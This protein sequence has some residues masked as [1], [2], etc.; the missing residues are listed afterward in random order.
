MKKPIS[1][2]KHLGDNRYKILVPNPYI[3]ELRA[4][5]INPNDLSNK[6]YRLNEHCKFLYNTLRVL[7]IS[8][9]RAKERDY[10][11]N[12]YTG[13]AFS[14]LLINRD[15]VSHEFKMMIMKHDW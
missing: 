4:D 3:V 10:T 5:G 8:K 13:D 15:D 7:G 2:V 12:I 14:N 11:L 9:Q 1:Y 6:I